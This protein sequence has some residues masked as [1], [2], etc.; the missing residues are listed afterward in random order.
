MPNSPRNSNSHC[1][2]GNSIKG[3]HYLT[4]DNIA[5]LKKDHQF[6]LKDLEGQLRQKYE[7]DQYQIAGQHL[8]EL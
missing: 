7:N 8:N 4:K 2:K 5:A 3:A 6:A 1:K